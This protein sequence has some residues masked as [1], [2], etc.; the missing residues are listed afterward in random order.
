LQADLLFLAFGAVFALFLYLEYVRMGRIMPLGEKLDQ[1]LR[2]FI[3]D[4]DPG[5]MIVSHTYLLL[6]CAV[7]V[8]LAK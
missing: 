3:D 1:F 5:I 8:W 4:R 6:G 2:S 7:P